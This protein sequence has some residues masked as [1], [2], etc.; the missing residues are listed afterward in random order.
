MTHS[1]FRITPQAAADDAA[2]EQLLDT[3]FGIDRRTKT[4]YRLREGET[5]VAG[6][7]FVAHDDKQN[8]IGAIS[9]WRVHIGRHGPDTLLLGPLAVMPDSQSMGLG[10]ALM[11]HGIAAAKAAGHQLIILVGDAPY[12]ARAGF[13]KVPHGQI[14]MPGPNDPDR[15]LYLELEPN[16]LQQASGLIRSPTRYRTAPLRSKPGSK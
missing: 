12:Y 5:P 7:S 10:Q 14:I 16:T 3:A 1:N 2:V 15:L 9:F 13:K 4:S 11:V 6:L 8:I